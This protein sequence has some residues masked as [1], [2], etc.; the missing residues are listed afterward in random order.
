MLISAS[1]IKYPGSYRLLQGDV[2]LSVHAFV[3][4]EI[5]V[6]PQRAEIAYELLDIQGNPKLFFVECKAISYF[7]EIWK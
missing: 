6:N 2:G 7:S 3:D 4:R 1:N 5:R